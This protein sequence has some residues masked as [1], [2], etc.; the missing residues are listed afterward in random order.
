MMG[1]RHHATLLGHILLFHLICLTL[2]VVHHLG[3]V[4]KMRRL[5]LHDIDEGAGVYV[6]D[7]EETCRDAGG[8]VAD[9]VEALTGDTLLILLDLAPPTAACVV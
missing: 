2:R 9:A 7:L 4:V 1:W 3:I 5:M 6:V 8:S